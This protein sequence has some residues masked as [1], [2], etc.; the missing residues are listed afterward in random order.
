LDQHLQEWER[1]PEDPSMKEYCVNDLQ[2]AKEISAREAKGASVVM[3]LRWAE[4]ESEKSISET[5]SDPTIGIGTE[6]I[7]MKYL[8]R[9]YFDK[10][11]YSTMRGG[12]V[13]WIYH[14]CMIGRPLSGK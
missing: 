1:T 2:F 12:F 13:H 5:P 11:I 3:L 9:S 4:Q 10:P 7:L 6:M 8:Q 14:S